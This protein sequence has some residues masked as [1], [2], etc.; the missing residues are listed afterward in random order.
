MHGGPTWSQREHSLLLKGQTRTQRKQCLRQNNEVEDQ[1][2]RWWIIIWIISPFLSR[3]QSS[4][5]EGLVLRT[6]VI[7]ASV[8]SGL[9]WHVTWHHPGSPSCP[10]SLPWRLCFPRVGIYP[11][12]DVSGQS[13]RLW[14]MWKKLECAVV[15][16]SFAIIIVVGWGNDHIFHF[17]IYWR[18]LLPFCASFHGFYWCSAWR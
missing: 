2:Q 15:V 16:G 6:S 18:S 4:R 11:L 10:W 14:K 8:G 17:F 3:H 7:M 1:S 12:K 9:G 5:S 13:G